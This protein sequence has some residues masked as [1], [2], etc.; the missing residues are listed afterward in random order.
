MKPESCSFTQTCHAAKWP[1]STRRLSTR[2]LQCSCSYALSVPWAQHQPH[3]TPNHTL[4]ISTQTFPQRSITSHASIAEAP[5]QKE[6]IETRHADKSVKSSSNSRKMHKQSVVQ[7]PASRQSQLESLGLLEWP[8]LCQQVNNWRDLSNK[9]GIP[10]FDT[11]CFHAKCMS[12]ATSHVALHW[13]AFLVWV[14]HSCTLIAETCRKP[15]ALTY[16]NDQQLLLGGVCP[17]RS[18]ASMHMY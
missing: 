7:N 18:L 6:A 4:A 16:R 12:P 11:I 1:F 15:S 8:E 13:I 14:L 17:T 5:V 10:A 9:H 3:G 2:K